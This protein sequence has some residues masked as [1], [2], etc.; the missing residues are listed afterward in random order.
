MR[1][2]YGLIEK[3]APSDLSVVVQGETGT[4]KELVA[5]AI[6]Q[7]SRRADK[8]LVIF[9]CSAVPEHL[10][11]SE[12]FLTVAGEAIKLRLDGLCTCC[13]RTFVTR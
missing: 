4:G 11:E 3:L 5:Q 10:I 7:R 9:D 1:G 12:L 8:P 13:P 6:H 2:I